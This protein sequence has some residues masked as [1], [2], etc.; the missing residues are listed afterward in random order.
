LRSGH[1][2]TLGGVYFPGRLPAYRA[3]RHFVELDDGDQIVLHDDCPE[4][5][6]P[7]DR[8]AL[9]LHGLGG[10]HQS[11]YMC[12]IAHKLA[13]AGVRAFR[14]DLRGCGAG[15]AL[16]RM[17]YHSGRSEDA[18]AALEFVARHCPGSPTTLVGFSL[19]GNI[20]LKLLGEC[21]ATP[22][23]GLD[24]A[25]A[26]NPPIDLLASSAWMARPT[27]RLYDRYFARLLVRQLAEWKAVA[28][29]AA[30]VEFSRRPRRLVE[31]DD[32]F[33]APVC[34]FGTAENYYRTCSS[35]RFVSGIRLPTLIIAAQDDPLIPGH[36]FATIRFP[37]SVELRM[38][39]GGGHLGFIGR[40]GIDVDRRW[41]DWR[42]VDWVV[43]GGVRG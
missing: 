25:M 22:P 1:A 3:G 33:T 40:R 8:T 31:L 14:M 16:A 38:A 21:G 7:G 30:S 42:V 12:R 18:T 15:I 5:W 41:M 10:S 35:A 29:D 26:V 19:G 20:V 17:P 6:R 4:A 11:A 36:S 2:Q 24:T 43:Q 37:A 34:G 23:G 9:L 27:S 13:D 28:P 39:P 32:A